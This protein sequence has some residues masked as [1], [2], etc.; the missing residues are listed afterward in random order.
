MTSTEDVD[1]GAAVEGRILEKVGF[2]EEAMH[3]IDE[4]FRMFLKLRISESWGQELEGMRAWVQHN[5]AGS[6]G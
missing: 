2:Y 1:D 6:N 3:L 5:P 4:M